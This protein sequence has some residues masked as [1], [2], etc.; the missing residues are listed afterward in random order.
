[1]KRNYLIAVRMALFGI[2]LVAANSL[3][4]Q[5]PNVRATTSPD[6]ERFAKLERY[7]PNH[8]TVTNL[9]TRYP[10]LEKVKNDCMT[11]KN[12]GITNVHSTIAAPT[13]ASAAWRNVARTADGRELWGNITYNSSWE[14]YDSR[15]IYTFNASSPLNATMLSTTGSYYMEGNGG[16]VFQ[17]DKLYITRW[18]KGGPYYYIYINVYDTDTWTQL[19]GDEIDDITFIASETA[20]NTAT[21]ITY[22]EFYNSDATGFVLGTVDYATMTRKDFGT[23]DNTY[24]ALGVTNDNV[25]YGVATDG[26]LYSISTTDGT[27]TLIGSTG[28]NVATTDGGH[29]GQSGEIDQQTGVFYWVCKDANKQTSLYTV[30]LSTGA[31]TKVADFSGEETVYG[32]YVPASPAADNA[33][34]A[35]TDVEVLFDNG[36][37]TG[38]VTFTAPTT[39]YA[40]GTLEGTL[41]YYIAVGTDTVAHGKVQPGDVVN[42]EVTVPEGI[43]TFLVSTSNAAGSSPVA[44]SK[45]YVGNDEPKP[46]QNINLDIDQTTGV[47]TLTWDAV[48]EGLNGGYVGNVSYDV[49]RYPDSVTVA[50]T[51]SSTNF[52]ETLSADAALKPYYYGVTAV[53]G[54][55]RSTEATSGKSVFGAAI[56][57]PYDEP[58][59]NENAFDLYTIIDNN[60]DGA[61]WEYYERGDDKAATY[62]YSRNN[63]GDDWLITPAIQLK[64]GKLYSLS[65][66]TCSYGYSYNERIEVKWG[67]SPTVEGMTNTL[68]EPTDVLSPSYT[69]YTRELA[70]ESDKKI[71]VGFHAISPA[72]EYRLYLRNVSL[73]EGLSLTLPDSVTALKVTADS[74]GE[75]KVAGTFVTPAVTL[76][77]QTLANALTHVD[78]L[79]TDGSIVQSFDSP[80]AAAQLQFEDNEAK[81]G[82][83]TYTVKVYTAEGEGRSANAIV[84]V[85]IDT[86]KRPTTPLLTDQTSSIHMQ[87]T[88]VDSVGANGGVVKTDDVW[89]KVYS[90]SGNSNGSTSELIDSVKNATSFDLDY[91][92]DKGEQKAVQF[93]LAAATATGTSG[94]AGSSPLIVGAPYALPIHESIAKGQVSYFWWGNGT[95]NST[96]S[97]G[98]DTDYDNDGGCFKLTTSAPNET[99]WINSGK[100]SLAGATTP[101]VRFSHYCNTSSDMRLTVEVQKPNGMVDELYTFDYGTL[102]STSNDEWRHASVSLADYVTLPYVIVRFRGDIGGKAYTLYVDD[103]NIDNVYAD[104][105]TASISA[106]A[107]VRKGNSCQVKVNVANNG[108]NVAQNYTV[109]LLADDIEVASQIVTQDLAPMTS[110]DFMFSYQSSLFAKGNDALLKAVVEFDGDGNTADNTATTQLKLTDPTQA[111]PENASAQQTD[112]GSVVVNWSAPSVEQVSIIDDMEAYDSWNT[113][114]FGDW[115]SIYGGDKG[116]AGMLYS[117]KEYP[118]QGERFAFIEFAPNDWSADITAKNPSLIPHSGDKYLAAV[119]SYTDDGSN[120]HFYDSNDWLISPS[121]SGEAQTVTFWANNLKAGTTDYPEQYDLLYSTQGTDTTKFIKIGDTRILSGGSWQQVSF[122]VPQG[123]THFAI[124]HCTFGS[125]AFM[126]MV[127]DVAYISGNGSLK[128]YNIYRDSALIGTVS[129]ENMTF[130]DNDVPTGNHSY[131]VTA[132]YAEGESLPAEAY[133]TTEIE[134]IPIVSTDFNVYTTDGRLVGRHLKS[135]NGLKQGTYVV[136]D[137]TVVVK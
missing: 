96:F 6:G 12:A 47:A 112:D 73:Y 58:F 10:L 117:S 19:S 119:Y 1:M 99:A 55:Q 123:A 51:L 42:R 59:D 86:P 98:T 29:Y 21:G 105:L 82:F 79:R 120:T 60:N 36:Q 116:G 8:R 133:V 25:L 38:S 109:R 43:T 28:V 88:P 4:A 130:T 129:P 54:N 44:K 24:V 27:E 77:G 30:D 75:L 62:K 46:V 97:I 13:N 23:S 5:N 35:A 113:D 115:T 104:N 78:V 111:Q 16:A 92:T 83:N 101:K 22:G 126:F 137:H 11:P 48:T 69:K 103:I 76:G 52:T 125:N 108:D 81:H 71:F 89:Y 66:E 67:N 17:D 9:L 31:A 3:S 74:D 80:E 61:T 118:H 33:P 65:F 2:G 68:L 26:N 102:S 136:N 94:I 128:G 121:L 56:V 132:V 41:D 84:F 134:I 95:G 49:V 106:P 34:A 114:N 100:L 72:D 18:F 7:T 85:G 57:P 37:T 124:H 40:G 15:G 64:G 93:G 110:R 14:S 122:E 131:A 87:W 20:T 53:N 107:Q 135:L 32:L 39:T 91:A 90:V 70:A 127:D 45:V 63:D 50:N